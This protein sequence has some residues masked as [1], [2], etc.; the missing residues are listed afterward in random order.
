MFWNKEK[1]NQY[2]RIKTLKLNLNPI[3]SNSNQKVRKKINF[4]LL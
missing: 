4:F 3:I 2:E 1:Y